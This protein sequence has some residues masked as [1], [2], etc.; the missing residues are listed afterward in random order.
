MN[1]A[2]HRGKTP[3]ELR[4][5]LLVAEEKADRLDRENDAYACELIRLAA[6]V[7]ARTGE[8]DARDRELDA[9]RIDLGAAREDTLRLRVALQNATSISVAVIGHRDIEC[10]N[11]VTQ[12]VPVVEPLWRA[13]GP[14]VTVDAPHAADP[15]HIPRTSW[16]VRD[17]QA[18][19]VA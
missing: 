13:L 11:E 4:K 16:A 14:V 5:L 6:E 10:G 2:K 3:T 19:E 12:P 15:T 17:E 1:L 9:T 8:R 18:E 7:D